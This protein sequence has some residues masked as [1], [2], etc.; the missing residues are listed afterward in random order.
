MRHCDSYLIDHRTLVLEEIF[1]EDYKSKIYT[2]H[3]SYFS[4]LVPLV[5]LNKACI[6]HASTMEGRRKAASTFFNYPRKTPILIAPYTIGV[7]PT[8]SP[9]KA[10]CVWIFNHPFQVEQLASGESLV[11]F[12]QG[13]LFAVKISKHTLLKQQQRLHTMLDMYRNSEGQMTLYV[14]TDSIMKK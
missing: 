5:L 2:T 6:R 7:F 11:K 9:K 10:E 12:N 3:G 13:T 1:E 4:K 14:T 8:M